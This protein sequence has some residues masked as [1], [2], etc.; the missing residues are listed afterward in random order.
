MDE[1]EQMRQ[2]EMN[3]ILAASSQMETRTFLDIGAND[4]WLGNTCRGLASIGWKG[5]M[6]EP[7]PSAFLRL[8][9][10]VKSKN[11]SNVQC[12]L[13]AAVPE[14]PHPAAIS[15]WEHNNH[16]LSTSNPHRRQTSPVQEGYK[17]PFLIPSLHPTEL[18]ALCPLLSQGVGFVNIDTE[19]TNFPL[20]VSL[21]VEEWNTRIVCVEHQGECLEDF[22]QWVEQ[23]NWNILNANR[24]NLLLAHPSIRKG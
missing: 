12:I 11:W 4:G 19:G 22:V 2:Q 15:F 17:S 1:V 3:S 24:E 16:R 8:L 21:P 20:L 7:S 13:C 10:T 23:K 5:L 9:A 6:V 14:Q 18:Q